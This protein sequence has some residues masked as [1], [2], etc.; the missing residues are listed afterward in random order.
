VGAEQDLADSLLIDSVVKR[1]GV[2]S[3]AMLFDPS[4]ANA[5]M[6]LRS[7]LKVFLLVLTFFFVVPFATYLVF[8]SSLNG[9]PRSYETSWTRLIQI[10]AYSMACFIPGCALLVL[11]APFGRARWVFTILLASMTTFYQ[12]KEQIETCKRYLTKQMFMKLA[13]GLCF[14]NLLFA[15]VVK[16]FTSGSL[17]HK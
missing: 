16:S 3:N 7:I 13:A 17:T 10:Y 12:Y 1:Y 6:A 11:L 8:I 4:Q 15:I 2:V 9:A 14:S 5:N